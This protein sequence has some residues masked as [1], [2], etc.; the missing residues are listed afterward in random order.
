MDGVN[1]GLKYY[2]SQEDGSVI[3][4]DDYL[5]YFYEDGKR[6]AESLKKT[7]GV[8]IKSFE[9]VKKSTIDK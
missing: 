3:S 8:Q 4:K 7:I 9:E 1:G 2:N 5:I 6:T